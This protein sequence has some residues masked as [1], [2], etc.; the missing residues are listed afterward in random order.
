MRGTYP[1]LGSV[2][3]D[4]SGNL[5]SVHRVL[6]NGDVVSDLNTPLSDTDEA[7][8]LTAAGA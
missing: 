1:Q 2:L 4:G 5:Q 8:F 7:D 3:F 6:V